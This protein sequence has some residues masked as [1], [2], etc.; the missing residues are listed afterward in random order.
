MANKMIPKTFLSVVDSWGLMRA[1]IQSIDLKRKKIMI[2]LM[3]IPP[4]ILIVSNSAFKEII[5]VNVPAPASNG[6]AIGT[7]LPELL[8]PASDLNSSMPRIISM[9]IKNI[10]KEPAKANEEISMPNRPKI[11]APKNRNAI[12]I[13]TAH[14]VT[15]DGLNSTPSFFM[16]IRMGILPNIS[17]TENNITDT[18]NIAAKFISLSS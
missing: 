5:V 15:T 1:A 13:L 17:I 3:M 16:L 8:S 2:A 9:P 7:I 10:T 18:D 11:E 6:K 14:I 4:R 12:I